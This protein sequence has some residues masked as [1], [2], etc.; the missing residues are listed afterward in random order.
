MIDH[1][2]LHV[3]DAEASRAFYEQALAPLG[4]RVVMEPA[5]PSSSIPTATTSR[6]STTRSE[7]PRKRSER[8]RDRGPAACGR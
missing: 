6:P 4:Y 2:K 3:A 1:I 5:A 8:R 7:P